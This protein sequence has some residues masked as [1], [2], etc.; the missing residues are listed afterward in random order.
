MENEILGAI[1]IAQGLF[2]AILLFVVKWECMRHDAT[3]KLQERDA[4]IVEVLRNALLH[5]DK[6]YLQ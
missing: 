5:I 2:I 4:T 6:N 3:K 1:L